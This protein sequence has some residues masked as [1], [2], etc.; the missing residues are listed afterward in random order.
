MA[1]VFTLKQYRKE[2]QKKIRAIEKNANRSAFKASKF[3]ELKAK[4]RAPRGMGETISGITSTKV[5]NKKYIVESRVPGK[6]GRGGVFYQN[7]WA[8]VTGRFAAPRMRWNKFDNTKYGTG[9]ASYTGTPGFFDIATLET[10][11]E[12]MKVM[13]RGMRNAL[14]GV[15]GG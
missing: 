2:I 13:R 11:R 7:M 12:F 1:R 6:K 14:R 4:I 10:R 15:I 8:N 5:G 3:M 9:P